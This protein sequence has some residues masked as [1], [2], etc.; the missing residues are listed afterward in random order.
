M[1]VILFRIVVAV[2][3]AQLLPFIAVAR[4]PEHILWFNY[5]QDF[6]ISQRWN[7]WSDV[8]M[9]MPVDDKINLFA[10]R[11]GLVY[12]LNENLSV[13]AGGAYFTTRTLWSWWRPEWRPHVELN[14]NFRHW[15]NIN[16]VARIRLEERLIQ[17]HESSYGS[18]YYSWEN[19]TR[20]RTRIELQHNLDERLVVSVGDEFFFHAFAYGGRAF[21]DHNRLYLGVAFKMNNAFTVQGMCM[22]FLRYDDEVF[23]DSFV[24][25]LNLRHTIS[26][27]GHNETAG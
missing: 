16:L 21:M 6:R 10:I 4:E 13:G 18:D 3:A 12:S 7:I 1:K 25:R 20:V 23:S 14:G 15:K 22:H 26:C 19:T 11:S 5:I 27:R 9:R 17:H 2:V 24:Y 8:Q